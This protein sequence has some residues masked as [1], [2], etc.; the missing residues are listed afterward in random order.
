MTAEP[1]RH[2]S[3]GGHAG[4][5]STG[6]SLH[7]AA[8]SILEAA[9]RTDPTGGF[10]VPNP[11]T[12]PWQWLWD[13]CFHA[14]AWAHLGDERAVIELRSALSSQDAEGFVPHIRYGPGPA[15]H[16]GLW[17]RPAESSITQPPVYGHAVAELTRLGLDLDEELVDRARRGLAFLLERR[18]R[19]PAGLVE[20]CH[21]WESGCDDSP[22]WDDAVP[23]E[24]TPEAWYRAKGTLVSA[25]ERTAGGAALHNPAFA[26]GSVGFSALV[27]WSARELAGITGDE[28][29]G[30]GAAELAE[31]VD[32][33]WCPELATWVDDGPTATGSGRVRTLDALLPVLLGDRAEAL[34]QLVA[35]EAFGAPCGPRG[36]HRAEP[37]YEPAVYWRGPAWPQLT[38]LLWLAATS[39]GASAVARSLA[40]SFSSG[41]ARSGFSEYW[42]P[43]SGR[44]LGAVPQTW[45]TL[46]VTISDCQA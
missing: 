6:T 33:R 26:V 46:I 8:S 15:P 16:A 35:P 17:G 24:R 10:C 2:E 42:E 19:S 39:S 20:L 32:A 13:S 1:E 29:L 5:L 41:V 45:S 38:Y 9:W 11:T 28:R 30:R 3:D 37:S 22:R 25:I 44:S 4:T 18:R 14:V 43:E 31:L 7:A 34:D 12:Y 36:V 23:G 27:A 40:R 21:P